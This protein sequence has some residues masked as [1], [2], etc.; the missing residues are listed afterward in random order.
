MVSIVMNHLSWFNYLANDRSLAIYSHRT[1]NE[2]IISLWVWCQV[3]KMIEVSNKLLTKMIKAE[4]HHAVTKMIHHWPRDFSGWIQ[5]HIT[6][7]CCVSL[8]S[9]RHLNLAELGGDMLP[10][11]LLCHQS[12]ASGYMPSKKSK[13]EIWIV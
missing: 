3:I 2:T 7:N 5:S 6:W 1:H 13:N 8:R 11:H 10:W 12:C 9:I 4:H